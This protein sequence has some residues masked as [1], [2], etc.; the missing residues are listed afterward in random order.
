LFVSL[1]L[2]LLLP[3]LLSEGAASL[4]RF[5]AL[6]AGLDAFFFGASPYTPQFSVGFS[7]RSWMWAFVRMRGKFCEGT[8]PPLRLLVN[9]P[10]PLLFV[11]LLLLLPPPLRSLDNVSLADLAVTEASSLSP[12]KRVATAREFGL[13]DM[14]G[15]DG[16][17]ERKC[18]IIGTYLRGSLGCMQTK[19]NISR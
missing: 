8:L 9:L 13:R 17:N 3:L 6:D 18:N 2:L 19:P 5:L 10:L 4:R 1:L 7:N 11:R 12:G 14:S 16:Q 15:M